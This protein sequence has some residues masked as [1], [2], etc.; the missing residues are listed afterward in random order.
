MVD[1]LNNRFFHILQ[2]NDVIRSGLRSLNANDESDQRLAESLMADMQVVQ[3]RLFAIRH[4]LRKASL[5]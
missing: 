4:T 3:D 5:V 2:L 1:E